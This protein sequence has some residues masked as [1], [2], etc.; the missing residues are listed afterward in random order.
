MTEG[1]PRR[2]V[3][4]ARLLESALKEKARRL[5]TV[6]NRATLLE[7]AL[8]R[9]GGRREDGEGRKEQEVLSLFNCI[10]W[11]NRLIHIDVFF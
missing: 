6:A 3:N 5:R 8:R 9:L 7:D 4:R 1:Q 10:S 2:D 11:T